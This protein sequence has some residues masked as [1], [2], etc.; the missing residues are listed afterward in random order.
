M[1]DPQ[2]LA[3]ALA[4]ELEAAASQGLSINRE[5][6]AFRYAS[7][8]VFEV[9]MD[10]SA[11][12]VQYRLR[13]GAWAL[14]GDLTGVTTTDIV[15]VE[16]LNVSIYL[17]NVKV[18]ELDAVFTTDFAAQTVSADISGHVNRI[19]FSYNGPLA[20]WDNT[21]VALLA[22]KAAGVAASAAG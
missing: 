3:A 16:L 13:S 10:I 21:P 19:P 14:R 2:D 6:T 1:N 11:S 15:T 8:T 4:K 12:Q 9:Q 18:G 22:E 20:A 7:S 5:T 17:L